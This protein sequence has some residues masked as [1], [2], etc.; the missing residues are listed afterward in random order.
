MV[1]FIFVS[2]NFEDNAHVRILFSV[3]YC[4]LEVANYSYQ[5]QC[6]VLVCICHKSIQTCKKKVMKDL[7]ENV[8]TSNNLILEYNY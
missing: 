3:N 5:R 1:I 6:F 7:S 8:F 2:K 4:E